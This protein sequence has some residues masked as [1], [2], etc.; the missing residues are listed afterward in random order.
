MQKANVE[1]RDERAARLDCR[2]PELNTCKRVPE[3]LIYK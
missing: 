3:V 2:W 1:E